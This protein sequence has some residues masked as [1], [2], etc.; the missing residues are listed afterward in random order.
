MKPTNIFG[1]P[2]YKPTLTRYNLIDMWAE[3]GEELTATESEE[4]IA[5]ADYFNFPTHEHVVKDYV[6][7]STSTVA[8]QFN[9]GSDVDGNPC[10]EIPMGREPREIPTMKHR[11]MGQKDGRPGGRSYDDPMPIGNN[12]QFARWCQLDEVAKE[13]GVLSNNE[14]GEYQILSCQMELPMEEHYAGGIGAWADEPETPPTDEEMA[15]SEIDFQHIIDARELAAAATDFST[16]DYGDNGFDDEAYAELVERERL[17][18]VEE[19][20]AFEATAMGAASKKFAIENS[21]GWTPETDFVM[22][23]TKN[24]D[25]TPMD[26]EQTEK[27]KHYHG[28]LEG[29]SKHD[30]HKNCRPA[31]IDP[32]FTRGVGRVLAFG[33]KK[34]AAGNWAKGMEWSRLLDAMGRHVEAF[35]SGEEIDIETGE[36]HLYHAGCMLQFLS[37]HWERDL[38]TD[39]R[40]EVGLMYEGIGRSEKNG[41][42]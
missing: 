42:Q 24:F 23:P 33:A 9:H 37:S 32:D 30:S 38:G 21:L 27:F 25:P 22:E 29:A 41:K 6:D 35:K 18:Q 12:D 17:M 36:C 13:C 15:S 5:L 34:Y 7:G 8:R 19:D 3:D 14:S 28:T 16:I 31:L 10:A 26:V 20:E 2:N 40:E 1:P 39:D 11:L 4:Y